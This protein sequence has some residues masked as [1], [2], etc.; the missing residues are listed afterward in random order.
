MS[1]RKLDVWNKSI[2]LV[3]AVYQLTK[4]LPP[5][6]KFGLASQIQR[7]AVS[8]SANIAEGYGRSTRGEYLQFLSM[9]NG[10]LKETETLLT[11][12]V[13]VDLVSREQAFD[14]W[15]L[16][17]TAGKMLTRLIL[18]LKQPKPIK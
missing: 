10:S 11:I 16:A 2:E 7:S 13:K 14:A 18:S 12:L 4:S 15:K 17:Q 1:Y 8:V 3:I 6:E 5:E 9:A